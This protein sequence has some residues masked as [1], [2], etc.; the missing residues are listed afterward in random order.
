MLERGL[1]PLGGGLE[2]YSPVL[3]TLGNSVCFYS[4]AKH[5]VTL[6]SVEYNKSGLFSI[7]HNHLS[8]LR[9]YQ[10]HIRS[11]AA[12]NFDSAVRQGMLMCAVALLCACCAA[13][14]D[15]A[16]SG[17]DVKL[18]D[19]V[20]TIDNPAG[21][22]ARPTDPNYYAA[23]FA[24]FSG[25]TPVNDDTCIDDSWVS[26][27]RNALGAGSG[28]SSTVV[29]AT[30]QD[31]N[32]SFPSLS[33][34]LY[35]STVNESPPAGQPKC[36]TK[37]SV[38]HKQL[39][40]YL[41]YKLSNGLDIDLSFALTTN[42]NSTLIKTVTDDTITMI[43]LVSGGTAFAVASV[44]AKATLD[45]FAGHLDDARDA[46]K[47]ANAVPET[48]V[49]FSFAGAAGDTE[50]AWLVS[51]KS[52]RDSKSG[53]ALN[54]WNPVLKLY[55]QYKKSLIAAPSGGSFQW[56][57]SDVV[58][59]S[60]MVPSALDKDN[61]I[62]KAITSNE[63]TG[64]STAGLSEATDPEAMTGQC[65]NINSWLNNFLVGDDV[66]VARCAIVKSFTKYDVNPKIRSSNCFG[67]DEINR[68]K[69]L[70]A[71]YTFSAD[72]PK[73]QDRSTTITSRMNA[74]GDQLD[75]PKDN[76]GSDDSVY[77][78]AFRYADGK[79][80]LF[81]NADAVHAFQT[82]TFGVQCFQGSGVNG[83]ASAV[84]TIV[85]GNTSSAAI[86]SFDSQGKL[87]Q[88]ELNSVDNVQ[89]TL[90]LTPDKWPATGHKSCVV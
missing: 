60:A 72:V 22:S 49:H 30:L 52:A 65:R 19:I 80:N 2:Q 85:R 18:S 1:F 88:V 12:M 10:N 86:F 6:Y 15:S 87:S 11:G 58:L 41:P 75:D 17:H 70:S 56:P 66:L 40:A 14:A 59:D 3:L 77:A 68:L 32:E 71:S 57:T 26:Y 21:K 54:T 36:T 48:P 28:N 83:D 9:S 78:K 73:T 33:P 44:G 63:A 55:M 74:I 29:T 37:L 5:S 8:C 16:G 27:L 24:V 23:L 38:N 62:A 51:V 90:G 53:A 76:F 46:I 13:Q 50:D 34:I 7:C 42:S 64:L 31:D 43:G 61:T 25:D 20:T 35:S 67:E 4:A 89:K 84:A 79:G 69:V 81:F 47:S 39:T 45:T 82:A